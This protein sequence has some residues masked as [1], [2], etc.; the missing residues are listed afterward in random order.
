M[1]RAII[2]TP[3]CT[4]TTDPEKWNVLKENLDWA[5]ILE[6]DEGKKTLLAFMY[7]EVIAHIASGRNNVTKIR[8]FRS[9]IIVAYNKKAK[10]IIAA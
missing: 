8:E 5:Y 9:M 7:N 2:K 6:H 3:S 1:G 4:G 10:K